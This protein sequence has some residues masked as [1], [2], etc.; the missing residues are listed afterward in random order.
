M[1]VYVLTHSSFL[2]VLY[3]TIEQEVYCD[4][5]TTSSQTRTIHLQDVKKF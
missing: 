4:G 3:Q 2:Y 5:V 1:F